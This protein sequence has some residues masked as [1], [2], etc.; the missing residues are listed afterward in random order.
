MTKP[1]TKQMLLDAI[2]KV[3][4]SGMFRQLTTSA[5]GEA[6]THSFSFATGIASLHWRKKYRDQFMGKEPAWLS[7]IHPGACSEIC[8][9]AIASKR[10]L[11]KKKPSGSCF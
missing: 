5:D 2:T 7:E 6:T 1:F 9:I 4:G 3:R 10:A 8:Q 11:P